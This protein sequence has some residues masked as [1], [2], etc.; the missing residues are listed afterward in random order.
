MDKE[1]VHS[2][3]LFNLK[4]EGNST[5]LSNRDESLNFMLGEISQS[6]KERYYIISLICG[7]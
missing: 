1:N 6:Q 7:T 2:G 3:I 5:V 4:K